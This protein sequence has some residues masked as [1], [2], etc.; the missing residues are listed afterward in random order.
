MSTLT[1]RPVVITG[2][3]V[4]T[5]LGLEVDAMWRALLD[6]ASGVDR[7]PEELAGPEL[8]VRI[9]ARVDDGALA[10]G[11]ER[12]RIDERDRNGQLALYAVGR[13]LDD[14]GLSVDGSVPLDLDVIVGSG[15]GA[16]GVSNASTRTYI[17]GGIRRVRPT[18]VVR[19]MFNRPASLASIRY[20][21][22]GTSFVVSAACASGSVALGEAFLRVALGISDAAV[23]ACC[24]TGGLDS[25][26]FVAWNRL[27]M[28]SR[29]PD[30]A[31]ASRPFDLKRDG[32]VLGEGAAAFVLEPRDHAERRGA[33]IWA[34]ILGYGA[35][36]DA[37]HLVRPDTGGQ[38]RAIRAA[39]SWAG[40]G[41]EAL[42]YVGAHG[43]ATE[44]AD[45]VEAAALREALGAHGGRVPVSTTKAQLGH[46]MG[47]TSGV[48]LAVTILALR[49][50]LLPPCRNLEDPD[51][52]CP[53]NFVR[54]EPL[55]VPA[56]VALKNT[57]A[58]GGTSCAVILGRGDRAV[59]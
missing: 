28:L 24:D 15:H 55:V 45:I 22:T 4:A 54:G 43:A 30:P 26:T 1:R 31:R 51:P 6:G 48:E 47:A 53:L 38:V 33:R 25:L 52:R 49:D 27:G 12:Y 42:D 17:E 39:L 50:G 34:H 35:A 36:S 57:F 59:A 2:I 11:L 44:Q 14:A 13:A 10:A 20:R 40:I 9:G 56:R 58:F 19:T 41:P 46:S 18:T 32:L 16:V 23:A 3:A 8:P 5:P 21:L 37:A 29:I 7:L